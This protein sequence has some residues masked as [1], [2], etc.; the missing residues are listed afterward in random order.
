VTEKR[1]EILIANN[2]QDPCSTLTLHKYCILLQCRQSCKSIGHPVEATTS[3]P[4]QRSKLIRLLLSLEA[5]QPPKV[6]S[7]WSGTSQP[8]ET[9][10]TL[11]SDGIVPEPETEVRFGHEKLLYR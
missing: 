11:G 6:A 7:Q 1:I 8:A 4:T 2:L 9:V 3:N 5:I 10:S